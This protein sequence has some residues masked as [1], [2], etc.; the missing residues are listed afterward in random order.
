MA[1]CLSGGDNPYRL[2]SVPIPVDVDS[3]DQELT[4]V[5]TG[6]SPALLSI[7]DTILNGDR[8]RI[9][10]HLLGRVETDAV[11]PSMHAIF[12]DIPLEAHHHAL[13]LRP[14]GYDELRCRSMFSR[15]TPLM[16]V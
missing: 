9:V 6:R 11:L 8:Q 4:E 16:T 2:N 3:H 1:V 7:H 12:A 15:G 13:A 5:H 10:E 14:R